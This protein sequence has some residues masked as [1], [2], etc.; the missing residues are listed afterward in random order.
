[1][2]AVLEGSNGAEDRCLDWS[3]GLFAEFTKGSAAVTTAHDLY[4]GC[5][6]MPNDTTVVQLRTCITEGMAELQLL[7]GKGVLVNLDEACVAPTLLQ[8]QAFANETAASGR[9]CAREIEE[10]LHASVPEAALQAWNLCLQGLG[11]S[12]EDAIQRC[13]SYGV[14]GVTRAAAALAG[15]PP[16]EIDQL[17]MEA[18]HWLGKCVYFNITRGGGDNTSELVGAQTSV[19]GLIDCVGR[20]LRAVHVPAADIARLETTCIAPTATVLESI[21]FRLVKESR[22]CINQAVSLL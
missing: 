18:S 3:V 16:S 8:F 21:G 17:V 13:M 14:D 2:Q 6:R 1:M 7:P 10:A 12:D 4:Q 20:V 9:T 5:R 19:K 15:T 22:H 11:G